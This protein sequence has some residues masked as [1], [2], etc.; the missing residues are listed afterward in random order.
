M[1]IDTHS[2]VIS[3]D[4]NRYPNAPLGGHK[5]EWSRERPV[6]T[7]QMIAAPN[8]RLDAIATHPYR[9]KYSHG[10]V[11][12]DLVVTARLVQKGLWKISAEVT[13][14]GA[15]ESA[16]R[17]FFVGH[18]SRVFPQASISSRK[19]PAPAAQQ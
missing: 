16:D 18:G 14:H 15:Q 5:S 9:V 12:G 3:T 1:V 17:I 2:H 13:N 8:L 7:E 10:L 11:N 19:D 6:S 4:T